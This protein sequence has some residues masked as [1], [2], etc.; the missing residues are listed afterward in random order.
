MQFWFRTSFQSQIEL[1]AVAHHFGD[2]RLHLI[3]L[4]GIDG[5]TFSLVAVFFGCFLEALRHALD[6]VVE[7]VGETQQ[8]RSLD[9]SQRQFVHH[10]AQ[11]H[12]HTILLGGNHYMALLVDVKITDTPSM[13]I[14]E[15]RRVLNMPFLHL[16]LQ[17][18]N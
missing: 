2:D 10:I 5:E 7:N 18:Y 8:H 3:D 13:N 6:A 1:L 17:F 12:L 15:L 11:V 4:D 9:I 14:V 16:I